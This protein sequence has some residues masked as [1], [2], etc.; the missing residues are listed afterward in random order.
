MD[1]DFLR[2]CVMCVGNKGVVINFI[3]EVEII[4]DGIYLF[5]EKV[6]NWLVWIEKVFKEKLELIYDFDE[7]IIVV[8]KVEE[9]EKEIEDVEN[10]KMCVMEVIE[11]IFLGL[12]FIILF[13]LNILFNFV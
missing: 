8:C 13:I 10:V 7:K 6:R 12:M 3:G 2:L 9:I 1:E 5:E 11:V 4:L